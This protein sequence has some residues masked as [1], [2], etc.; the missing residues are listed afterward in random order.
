MVRWHLRSQKTPTGATL[1]RNNK[2][3]RFQRGSEFLETRIQKKKAKLSRTFGGGAKVKLLSMDFVNIA[4]PKTG[5]IHKAKIL[6]VQENPANPHY[7]RRNILTKGAII[8][9]DAGLAKITSRPG[10]HGT[11]NAVAVEEKKA[12]K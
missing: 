2:K 12:S 1:K 9:T 11:I 3:K 8:K 4:D 6:S 5:K 7:V 10:Q